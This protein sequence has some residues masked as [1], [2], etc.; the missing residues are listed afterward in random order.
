[1]LSDTQ[2]NQNA[3]GYADQQTS[4]QTITK[5]TRNWRP[6]WHPH[7][8]MTYDTDRNYSDKGDGT[9]IEWQTDELMTNDLRA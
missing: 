9:L 6:I 8:P 3:S 1:M 5:M 7:Q 4:R 2:T